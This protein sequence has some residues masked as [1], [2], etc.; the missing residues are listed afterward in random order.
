[1]TIATLN[2]TP[3]I[4]ETILR[5]Q[6]GSATAVCAKISKTGHGWTVH[7]KPGGSAENG[8]RRE[9]LA[10]ARLCKLD[11]AILMAL[12]AGRP[13]KREV[14]GQPNLTD[15]PHTA[16]EQILPLLLPRKVNDDLYSYQRQG[17]AWLLCHSRALLGD[18]MG[19]GKTA[20][21]ISAARRLIRAGRMSWVLV[22]SPRTLIANWT[23]E[24]SF[25][26]P[27]L[28]TA[29]A[30]ALGARRSD[31]WSEL[32][33]RTHFL[34]T[35]YEQIREVPDALMR[36]PPDLVIAD[37]AHRLRNTGSLVT[38]GFRKIAS[39]RFW[40]LTGTPI[41]R[42]AEDLA[43]LL[44]LLD[45]ARFSPNDKSLPPMS[46]RA[47]LRPYLLRRRKD[48]VLAELPKIIEENEMLDLSEEQRKSYCAAIED[49]V[50][51]SPEGGVLPLFNRLRSIC[52]VDPETGQSCKLDRTCELLSDIRASGEKAVVFSYMLSPLEW[53]GRRLLEHD[54]TRSFVSISGEMSLEARENALRKFKSDP[55]CYVLLAST[56]VTSEGLTLT[57]ANHVL[58]INQWWNPSSNAQARDRVVRIGQSR[59]VWIKAF[60]CR[61]TVEERL[62]HVLKEKSL[63]F[64]QLVESLSKSKNDYELLN[65][66]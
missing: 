10:I 1:M 32:V 22:V 65:L 49:H 59:M 17:V 12:K 38:Q 60:T 47:R 53:L 64:D 55:N 24:A 45:S 66:A 15:G 33:R 8:S 31:R 5:D 62:Q 27:E 36:C 43:V 48:S 26:A 63:T 2:D 40:A 6:D 11:A 39:K 23:A 18:D 21:A 42:D 54:K 44:S 4:V 61:G 52:D 30:L 29:T 35:S 3:V 20:Q 51:S 46:L 14:P 25:W 57:E 56:R 7:I 19:L 37:E 34:F 16:V 13:I 41:E 50:K 58:F 9:R 28:S